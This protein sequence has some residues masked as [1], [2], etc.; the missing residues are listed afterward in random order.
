MINTEQLLIIRLKSQKTFTV[1]NMLSVASSSILTL[2]QVAVK[3]IIHNLNDSTIE[4]AT[5]WN[6]LTRDL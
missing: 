2:A 4:L 6:L 5:Y 3:V 1:V